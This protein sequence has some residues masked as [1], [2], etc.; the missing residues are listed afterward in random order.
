MLVIGGATD[1]LRTTA[2]STVVGAAPDVDRR[3][4]GAEGTTCDHSRVRSLPLPLVVMLC[5]LLVLARGLGLHAHHELSDHDHSASSVEVAHDHEHSHH[6]LTAE[7]AG[8]HLAVHMAHGEIDAD[9]PDKSTGKLPSTLMIALLSAIVTL[10]F[11]PR[12]VRLYFS[13]RRE[14]RPR[15]R[16]TYFQPLSHAPPL[17]G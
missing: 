14:H 1:D 7:M 13:V 3:L 10:L 6:D 16:W 8:D 5:L 9:S 15:R 12:Q 11:V 4:I 2:H 17:A